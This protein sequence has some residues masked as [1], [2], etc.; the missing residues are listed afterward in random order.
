M[1]RGEI[2]WTNVETNAQHVN[3]GFRPVLVVSNDICNET[4]QVVTV[5]PLTTADKKFMPTHVVT[6]VNGIKNTILCEHV[7]PVNKDDLK[8]INK[9]AELPN[10]TMDLVS[11]ALMKQLGIMGC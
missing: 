11:V 7:M 2:Y 10:G 6:H 1:H 4:P 8:L 5:V 9:F 3:K